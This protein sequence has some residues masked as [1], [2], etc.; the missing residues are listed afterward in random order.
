MR[1]RRRP[2]R[3]V[4]ASGM[5]SPAVAKSTRREQAREALRQLIAEGERSEL[6]E[7]TDTAAF[8]DDVRAEARSAIGAAG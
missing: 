1:R 6:T 3:G 7:V 2:R 5:S 8:V 4:Y